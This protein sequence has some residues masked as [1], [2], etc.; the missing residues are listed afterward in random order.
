VG[1]DRL[2]AE[3]DSNPNETEP[4]LANAATYAL[5]VS[6]NSLFAKCDNTRTGQV[7]DVR[8]STLQTMSCTA[9]AVNASL[10]HA[11]VAPH[12]VDWAAGEARHSSRFQGEIDRLR[13]L[14]AGSHRQGYSRT[15]GPLTHTSW[16]ELS[17]SVSDLISQPQNERPRA[18][19]NTDLPTDDGYR[20][21]RTYQ[22]SV[23]KVARQFIGAE[24]V[25][26][27]VH[28]LVAATGYQ[29]ARLPTSLPSA[30][31]AATGGHASSLAA[32]ISGASWGSGATALRLAWRRARPGDTFKL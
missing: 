13:D 28:D 21:V 16:D 5:G 10:A 23:R 26:P 8:L 27:L 25:A 15:T 3:C 14:A 20:H 30:P 24:T 31:P 12:F 1:A 6:A 29:L 9:S 2:F 22:T 11:S 7:G 18:W 4:P 17:R 19:R 32:H